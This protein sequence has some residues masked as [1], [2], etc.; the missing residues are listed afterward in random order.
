MRAS[1][2]LDRLGS[3]NSF[4]RQ[5]DILYG[6]PQE[7]GTVV[8]DTYLE[9]YWNRATLLLTD[10]DQPIEGYPVRYDINSLSLEINYDNKIKVMDSKRI[11][12]MVWMDSLT[13][14]P[15]YFVNGSNYKE[16]GAPLVGLI[17][18]LV[19]GEV[20]LVNK[21]YLEVAKPTYNVAMGSGSKD[22]KIYKRKTAYCSSDRTLTKIKTKRDIL[23]ISGKHNSEIASFMSD[24]HLKANDQA[25]LI[26]IFTKLNELLQAN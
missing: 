1:N 24:N 9:K 11:S 2:T 22:T 5:S 7:P 23:A 20:A 19:D 25:D 21:F 15:R 4:N 6:L 10:Y 14:E 8:G 17:E 3:Q 13:R 26:K 18:V 16:D 12:S